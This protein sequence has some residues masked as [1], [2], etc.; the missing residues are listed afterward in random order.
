MRRTRGRRYG[1]MDWIFETSRSFNNTI[2]RN[3]LR[4]DIYCKINCHVCFLSMRHNDF[5]NNPKFCEENWK[6]GIL[7]RY[8]I[9]YNLFTHYRYS[10][11]TWRDTRNRMV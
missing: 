10:L 1:S 3:A 5:N 8:R 9:A 11:G 7:W 2:I 6:L 4:N